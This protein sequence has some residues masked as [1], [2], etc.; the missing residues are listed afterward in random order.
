M[1][2]VGILHNVLSTKKK[3][4]HSFKSSTKIWNIITQERLSSSNSTTNAIATI[5][6]KDSL[7]IPMLNQHS[8]EILVPK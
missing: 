4:L 5:K 2:S 7:H 1:N 3:V 6:N 8:R